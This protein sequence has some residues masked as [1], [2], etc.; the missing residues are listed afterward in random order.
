MK[1]AKQKKSVLTISIL[2]LTVLSLLVSLVGCSRF[3]FVQNPDDGKNTPTDTN[4]DEDLSTIAPADPPPTIYY[5]RYTG[6]ACDEA[7]L[8]CRPISVCIGN[9][10]GT[11]QAGLSFADILIEAPT[12][13]DKTRLWAIYTDH[14][15]TSTVSSVAT[16]RDYM[17]PVLGAFG[18]IGAYAG[19]TDTVGATGTVY[20]GEHLDYL[21]HNLSSTFEKDTSG[22]IS[23]TP[24]ALASAALGRQ[25]SLTD[26]GTA[27]PYRLADV[28]TP[29]TPNSN[30]I[31]SLTFRYSMA[32][33]VGFRYDAESGRYYREQSGAAHT[34]A[35]T[36]EQLSFSNL[37]LLFHNVSYYH[38]S[39]NTSFSLDTKSGGDGYLYTGG[40]VLSVHWSYREDGTLAV[41]DDTGEQILLNRGKTY[42]G[43]LRVTDS[44]SLIAK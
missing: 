16:V 8:S 24:K 5:N 25:Y 6:L 33:T 18:A 7:L 22:I 32:N 43:M 14:T 29:F 11:R 37:L 26:Q 27:L 17:M 41:V 34:D 35:S 20:E 36:N 28:S 12:D 44:S 40:G 21:H 31:R 13:G 38:T 9:F 42:I 3:S 39:N 23:T 4:D 10:D 30:L 1:S 15:K 2:F 19:T